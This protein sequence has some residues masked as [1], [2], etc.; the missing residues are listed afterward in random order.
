MKLI[1]W[2]LC[3]KKKETI[4]NI[5]LFLQKESEQDAITWEPFCLIFWFE[6]HVC[7]NKI[8]PKISAPPPEKPLFKAI[9]IYSDMFL[10]YFSRGPVEPPWS[11]PQ[12]SRGGHGTWALPLESTP[13]WA[14]D[15]CRSYFAKPPFKVREAAKKVIF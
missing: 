11:L 9:F 2:N 4:R 7:I 13:A 8:V 1:K 6:I 10:V 14:R 12:S 15:T 5:F 3:S